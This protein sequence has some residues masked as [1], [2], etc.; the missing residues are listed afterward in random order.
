MITRAGYQYPHPEM[1]TC[2]KLTA[3]TAYLKSKQLLLFIFVQDTQHDYP[4]AIMQIYKWQFITT[5]LFKLFSFEC[6]SFFI[7]IVAY[8]PSNSEGIKCFIDK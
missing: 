7:G 1:Y 6:L 4:S 8:R 2:G 3:V 5:V